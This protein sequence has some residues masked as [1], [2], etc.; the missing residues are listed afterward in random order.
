M[1]NIHPT[2]VVAPQSELSSDVVIGPYSIIGPRVRIGPGTQVMAHAHIDGDTTIGGN[3]TVFPFASL[4]TQTQDLKYA[5]GHTRVEIGDRTTLR[6][7]VTVNSATGDGDVTRVGS[8]CHIMAYAHVAHD[9]RVGNHVI[10]ANCGTLAG[11]VTLEDHVIVGGLC[12]IHQF[13]RIGRLSIIGGCSKVTQDIPPY[14]MADGHPLAVHGVNLVGLKRR[15]MPADRI[16]LLK[17][18]YKILYREGLSTSRAVEKLK[19]EL[20]ESEEI[21]H[22]IEFVDATRRGIVK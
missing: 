18:A 22:I 8:D 15:E 3:C 11:H 14:M 6:E 5:G 7:Y 1:S 20:E 17:K 13:V 9:C 4:G 10:I 21:R 12:G 2:A 19:T 16:Q